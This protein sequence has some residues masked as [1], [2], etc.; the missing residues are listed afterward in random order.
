[1]WVTNDSFLEA[2]VYSY[3]V[4]L[5]DKLAFALASSLCEFKA[6]K[7]KKKSYVWAKEP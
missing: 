2:S 6:K 3:L 7:A 5:V 1:M 4:I